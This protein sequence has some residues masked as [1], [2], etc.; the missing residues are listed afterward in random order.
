VDGT[1]VADPDVVRLSPDEQAA[2]RSVTGTSTASA[3][4]RTASRCLVMAVM[5]TDHYPG[6]RLPAVAQ[7]ICLAMEALVCLEGDVSPGLGT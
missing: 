6:R 4:Q 5:L 7:M 1:D 2:S 3:S